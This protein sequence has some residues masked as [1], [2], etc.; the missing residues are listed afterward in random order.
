[1]APRGRPSEHHTAIYA[2][3]GQDGVIRYVGKANNPEGRLRQHLLASRSGRTPLHAWLRQEVAA[4]RSVTISTL[5]WVPLAR[6][7]DA[8]RR[9][10]TEHRKGGRL[11]NVADGG[12]QP[13]RSSDPLER[14]VWLLKKQILAA[15]KVAS[16][17]TKAAIARRIIDAAEKWGCNIP[18]F[19]TVRCS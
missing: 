16:P 18:P 6:W 4:N 3:S 11:L 15:I 12:D 5:E 1:M 14:R 9:L 8:E 13:K 2:L 10:I 17:E 19:P 7:Q